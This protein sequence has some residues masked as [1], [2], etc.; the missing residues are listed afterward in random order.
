MTVV[1][2]L[3]RGV[4]FANSDDLT[5]EM[6][7]DFKD[8]RVGMKL[9]NVELTM[10]VKDGVVSVENGMHLDNCHAAMKMKTVDVCGAID[11]SF[12]LME[13][14]EKGELLKGDPTDMSIAVHFMATFPYFDAMV[15]LY[16]EDS[17][18]KK[19]VDQVKSSL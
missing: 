17:E 16:Q 19:M 12:D 7:V 18:F 4:A 14:R 13:I 15:R 9:D 6:L 8:H 3:Q 5:K 11:N 10:V 2:V 1:D